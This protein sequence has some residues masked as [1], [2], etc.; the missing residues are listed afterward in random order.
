MSRRLSLTLLVVALALAIAVPVYAQKPDF[1]PHIYVDGEAWGTKAVAALPAPDGAAHSFDDLYVFLDQNGDPIP[2]SEQLL[3]GDAAPGDRDYNGGRWR[4]FTVR[5]N[6]VPYELTS[7]MQIHTAYVAGDID[8]E[9][10]SFEG[11]PPD[12]FE[13]PLLPVLY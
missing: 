3:V 4:V 9:Q 10:G 5:W 11:G 2:L 6:V 7:D 13:C 1:G 8:V 12:Y